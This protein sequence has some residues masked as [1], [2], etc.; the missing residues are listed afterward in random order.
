MK[1]F[2][3]SGILWGQICDHIENANSQV[4]L[5][6]VELILDGV[7]QLDVVRLDMLEIDINGCSLVLSH[8]FALRKQ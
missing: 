3:L 5:Q 1:I 2:T 7:S 6:V 4:R 8:V